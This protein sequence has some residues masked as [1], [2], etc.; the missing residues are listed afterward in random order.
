[1]SV[2][3]SV[4]LSLSVSLFLCPPTPLFSLLR[5]PAFSL[6]KAYSFPNKPYYRTITFTESF[7]LS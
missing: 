3:L 6:L 4:C 7:Q 5:Q 1:M 2:F